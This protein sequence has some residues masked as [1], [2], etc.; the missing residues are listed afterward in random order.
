MYMYLDG[1]TKDNIQFFLTLT[2]TLTYN[3]LLVKII[4]VVEI[5]TYCLMYSTSG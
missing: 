3:I 5:Y 2:F 1:Y 4:Y